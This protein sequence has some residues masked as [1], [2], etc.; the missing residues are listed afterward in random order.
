MFADQAIKIVK[1]LHASSWLP[2]YHEQEIRDITREIN[3]L[4][5]LIEEKVEEAGR[6]DVSCSLLI[7]FQGVLRNK[8]CVLAYLVNRIAKIEQ[9]WWDT[10]PVVPAEA[11]ELLSRKELDFITKFDGL[12]ETF[13]NQV[14]IDLNLDQRPPKSLFVECRALEDCGE[15]ETDHGV[16]QLEAHTVHLL[17]RRDAELLIRRGMLEQLD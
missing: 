8:R 9:M 10:G 17:K 11:R 2:P 4:N 7:H 5:A 3:A 14:D 13:M 12:L 16:L 15:I 1:E 6:E